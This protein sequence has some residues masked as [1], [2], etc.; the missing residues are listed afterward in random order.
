MPCRQQTSTSKRFEQF[1]KQ[2][3]TLPV[4]YYAS[5]FFV[6][7]DNAGL[8]MRAYRYGAISQSGTSLRLRRAALLCVCP[9]SHLIAEFRVVNTFAPQH[10]FRYA[11]VESWHLQFESAL[12]SLLMCG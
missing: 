1:R 5:L 8:Q 9:A 4:L 3:E 2:R 10:Q 11:G 7:G 12:V 6:G